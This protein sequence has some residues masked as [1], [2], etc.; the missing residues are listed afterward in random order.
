MKSICLLIVCAAILESEACAK[1]ITVNT[2]NNVSTVAGQ[3]N[4]VQALQQLQDG[5]AIHFNL[6]GSGPFYLITPPLSPDNGYPAITCNNVTID[7]YS[8]PGAW[9]NTNT[10]LGSNTAQIQIV[11][12]SRA[13]GF[14]LEDIPGYSLGEMSV[15]LVKGATNVTI[16]GLDF[17]GPG[18][19]SGSDDDPATYAISFALG[20]TNGHVQGCWFG[21]APDRTNVFRFQDAV[22]GFQGAGDSF[23]NGTTVGVDPN[24]PDAATARAEFNVIVGE[25]IPIILEGEGLRISGNFINVFPDGLTDYFSDGSPDHDLQAFMEFGGTADNLVIGTDGDG[26]NDAEERNIFGGVILCDDFNLFEW[27]GGQSEKNMVIAGNYIGVGVD[28]VTRFTNSMTLIA[29]PH[30]GLR[31]SATLRIG[32]DFDGVSDALE[33]NVISMNYPFATLFPSPTSETPYDFSVVQPGAAISFRGN[34]M[35]GAELAPFTYAD[36]FGDDLAK[37]ANYCADFIAAPIFP[38]LAT[39]STQALLRGTVAPGV[40]AFTNIVIDVYLADNEAWT[41]GQQFQFS[42]LAYP[43][44]VTGATDYYGFA[45][46]NTWLATFNV[47]SPANLDP[48]PGNF[49]FDI[50][51]LHIPADA[52]VTVA[53]SYATNA[54]GAHN[55]VAHTSPFALPVTLQIVPPLAIAAVGTN[56]FLTWPTNAGAFTIQT[57]AA[58]NPPAWANLNPPPAIQTAGTNYSAKINFSG[59]SA[60]FRLLR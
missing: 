42:E 20:A 50:S 13:G 43:D 57:T 18:T 32:S 24:A 8:Q 40:G 41:N 3:T 38:A 44:P 5:D 17:L 27:Y 37:L 47:N 33:G 51:A 16:R 56:I 25:Y 52:L 6:P 55:A 26:H 28:G 19:G 53:A 15:L 31:S 9:Q 34:K 46:G 2:T 29:G 14:R 11:L 12:D 60:F 45:E 23:P 59:P 54:P 7:G 10:I 1:I 58:L 35:L 22:T 49:A 21:V 36:G 30:G 4:F 48:T 39:N